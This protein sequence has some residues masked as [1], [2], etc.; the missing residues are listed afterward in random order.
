MCEIKSSQ[1]SSGISLKFKG[2]FLVLR[3]TCSRIAVLVA[4]CCLRCCK[5]GLRTSK[6]RSSAAEP[7]GSQIHGTTKAK[8]RALD[9][10]KMA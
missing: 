3:T 1:Q 4:D 9:C 6:R 8:A 10:D 2:A 7:A 5:T